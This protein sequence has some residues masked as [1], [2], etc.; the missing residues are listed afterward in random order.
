MTF[1]ETKYMGSK[2]NLL[3]FISSEI[4]KLR[5]KTA[6]DAFSGSGCVAYMLKQMGAR[7]YANDMLRFCYHTARATVENN[8]V[9]LTKEDVASLLS[10][11]KNAPSFIRENYTH[12]YF[13]YNDCKFLDNL[14]A[15]I[16]RINS[17]LKRSIAL[18]AACRAAMK[19]R[20]RGIFTFVGKKGWDGRKDLSL[21]MK[22][23]FLR[24]V[25]LFNEA[26]F[27]NG[28]DN[29]AFCADVFNLD[30][31]DVD[32]VYIDTPYV[33]PYSDCDYTRRYHFVEGYCVYWQGLEIMHDTK[34]K[35]IRSY[36]TPFSSKHNAIEAFRALFHHLRRSILV[37]SYSSNGI[38]DKKGML[39]LLKEVKSKVSVYEAPHKYSHGNH[40][41]KVGDNNNA[42]TE[43]VFIAQ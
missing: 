25:Q 23:Q 41:H 3:P 38:P 7:V 10:K 21:S 22:E 32:L 31:V 17:P 33:S 5:F 15:N 40:N 43:Y 29:R 8:S 1:P 34:T 27:S 18:A 9:I 11:N 24:A 26:V 13:D 30:P 39:Q 36:N 2:Q 20:P 42:A 14:W 37:V 16:S 4:K 19:K 12:L 28:Q 35:K 6:L